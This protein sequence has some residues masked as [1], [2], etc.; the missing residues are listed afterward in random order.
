[1]VTSSLGADALIDQAESFKT[2]LGLSQP[3]PGDKFFLVMGLTG[4]GKS[5]FVSN[6]T[7]HAVT[8]GHGLYSYTPGFNDTSRSDI[9]TLEVLA[10]YLGAS[11]ANGVRIHG[12]ISLYPITNNRMA[13]SNLRSFRILKEICGF[14]SYSNLAI[15]TTMWPKSQDY[16]NKSILED[17]ELELLTNSEF[18]SDLVSKGARVFRDYDENYSPADSLQR[19]MDSLLRQ[20][21]HGKPSVLQLQREVVDEDK[22]LGE[23]AAGIAAAEH[24]YQTCR[25][26]EKQLK[27]LDVELDRTSSTSEHEY[28]LQ[29]RELKAEVDRAIEETKRGSQALIK[30]MIDLHES[31]TQ[32][33]KERVSS[34]QS[35]YDAEKA[36]SKAE[37]D[38]EKIRRD[39]QKV[40][41]Y[42]KE[43]VGGVMNGIAASAVAGVIGGLMCTVIKWYYMRILVDIVSLRA[44]LAT[45]IMVDGSKINEKVLDI[46]SRLEY[47]ADSLE[48]SCGPVTVF[49]GD[50][51]ALDGEYDVYPNHF[52]MQL[53]NA[54]RMMRLEIEG[55]IR[56]RC[57]EERGD[58]I[59]KVAKQIC[60]SVT[61]SI[62][63]AR[64]QNSELFTQMQKLECRI[65]M[66]PLYQAAQ[67]STDSSVQEW[68]WKI[69]KHTAEKGNMR[70]ARNVLDISKKRL[71]IDYWTIGLSGPWPDAMQQ[72]H[73]TV[74]KHMKRV[75]T[76]GGTG[77]VAGHVID[78]LLK[79]SSP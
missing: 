10:T 51:Q 9:E 7:G 55:R 45:G 39:R 79:R 70:I 12:I 19:I 53:H 28:S 35:Q 61:H 57:H 24:L 20:L 32:A 42:T 31:E 3:D 63:T 4:A 14:D 44:M 41:A 62:M 33:L 40:Q 26:H 43:I 25:Q 69:L 1:M 58:V 17:R 75:W 34:L 52:T 18:F 48:R 16:T 56:D 66:A 36:L 50:W 49:W 30:T 27:I 2:F 74:C 68:I 60:R 21:D 6:C 73:E 38:A 67:V 77:F 72:Q 59:N 71:D 65:L 47:L 11:Y 76:L 64:S 46:N 29:L 13:G 54:V 8:I 5:T 15:V 22:S 78:V 23:T 37:K